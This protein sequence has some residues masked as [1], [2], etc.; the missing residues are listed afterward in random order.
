M[1]TST[2]VMAQPATNGILRSRLRAIAEPITWK[3]LFSTTTG[4]SKKMTYFCY[5]SSDDGGFGKEIEDIV[6]PS[7]K[8]LA[9][10]LCQVESSHTSQL[11]TKRLEENSEEVG[12]END[13]KMSISS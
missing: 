2:M 8:V 7:R 11:D 4:C 3:T 12:H 5:V 9:A 6:E 10:I 13:E 1:K